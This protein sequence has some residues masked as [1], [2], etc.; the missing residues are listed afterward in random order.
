MQPLG[1][2]AHSATFSGLPRLTQAPVEAIMHRASRILRMGLLAIM[3]LSSFFDGS[4][5]APWRNSQKDSRAIPARTATLAIITHCQPV[6]GR[7]EVGMVGLIARIRLPAARA[8]VQRRQG[9]ERRSATL[10]I[11]F[12]LR[13]LCDIRILAAPEA[14][15][16]LGCAVRAEAA[17][18]GDGGHQHRGRG[19]SLP[20]ELPEKADGRRE[21][22]QGL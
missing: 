13:R 6:R 12:T 8:G 16:Q 17:D 21:A 14:G 11:Q 20:E 5:Q 3:Y 4:I 15:E 9:D 18:G 10:V 7:S 19:G 1:V 2:L 22:A